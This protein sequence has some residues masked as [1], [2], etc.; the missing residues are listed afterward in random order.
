MDSRVTVCVPIYRGER[1]LEETLRTI[2][3]QTWRDLDVVMS[4]DGPD[5]ACE[6]ICRRFLDDPRFKLVIQPERL[7]WVGN[8]NWIMARV[9]TEFC[10]YH[11][12]DDLT[13]PTYAEV[14]VG[15]LKAN[16]SAA[17]AYCDLLPMG[18]ITGA[19]KQVP[20]V[21]G[22]SPFM[23]MM[24]MLHEHW[25]AFA[26][27]GMVRAE[28]VRRAGPVPTNAVDNFGV[29]I[30][31]LTAVARSGELHHV[32]APL[33]RKRYHDNNTESK[34][35]AWP[36]EK[37]L[38]AWPHHCVDML[39]Q[40][41]AVGGTVEE[42]RLMWLAGVERLTSPRTA[43]PF[44]RTSELT[45][46]QHGQMLDRFM[47]VAMAS[48]V[49]DIPVLLDDGWP[50][51]AEWTRRFLST[52][53]PGPIEIVAF[54]PRPVQAA[55]PFNV[56]PSGVSAMWLRAARRIPADCRLRLGGRDLA[57]AIN[58]DRATA[59]VP[60]EMT[61]RPGELPLLLVDAEGRPCSNTVVFSVGEPAKAS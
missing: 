37:K 28:A 13:D 33:Y 54:G 16:P 40:A 20:S 53:A 56:Q 35:W 30:C 32:A 34:W 31:W 6:A 57:T 51:I 29:D 19:F 8:F 43:R 38:E 59:A 58:L 48:K 10:Y 23:R 7:G 49:R 21:L 17:L 36:I 46:G 55:K 9:E 12:Q 50:G 42:M 4:L 2:V 47:A 22:A 14:L 61:E 24:T 39:N 27:R 44:L 25:G 1:F 60:A 11:Q 5:P 15:H 45:A 26:F 18:R 52:P 3:A 41:F